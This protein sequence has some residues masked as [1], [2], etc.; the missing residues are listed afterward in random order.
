MNGKKYKKAVVTLL[1]ALIMVLSAVP[2]AF[3]SNV[4]FTDVPSGKWY[5][6]AIYDMVE[7]GVVNGIGNNKFDPEGQVS[8]AQ[9][10]TMLTRLFYADEVAAEAGG[11][12]Y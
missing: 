6:A 12:W 10:F 8:I 4:A 2:T 3:A 7:R 11:R 5:S 9:Y 1:L